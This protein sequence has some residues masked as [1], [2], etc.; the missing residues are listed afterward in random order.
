MKKT[1]IITGCAG[2]IGFHLANKLSKRYNIIGIDKISNYYSVK[3]KKKRLE[4]L[5]TNKN[6]KFY[7]KDLSKKNSLDFLKNQK[8]YAIIHLAAQAGVR[9][10]IYKPLN[11]IS[12]N[13]TA[14]VNLYEKFKNE[15]LQKFIYASSSSIYGLSKLKKFS[16][17]E[18]LLDPLSFYSATK[19]S[20]EQISKYYSNLYKIPSIGLRFFTCY[21][22]WGRPDLSVTKITEGILK[23]KVTLLN[24]GRTK[25]DYTYIDDTV[26]GIEKC[27]NFNNFTKNYHE[28]FNIGTGKAYTISYLTK[29]LGSI[30]NI[31]YKTYYKKHH[32][33]DMRFTNADIKKSKKLLNYEPKVSLGD[34]LKKFLDW[35][36]HYEK[37]KR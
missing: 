31:K 10:S 12:D 14:Q 37:I 4:I 33:T 16:E 11:Y 30:L 19:Q 9:N 25:R 15:N 28:V 34:G 29:I 18:E 36:L 5:K 2:F 35:Y 27:L 21:G 20:I 17:N 7:K 8:I 13:I 1:L 26:L 3:L 6:F 22:P 32:P 24:N 23:K